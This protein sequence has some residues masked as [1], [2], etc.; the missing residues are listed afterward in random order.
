MICK[1]LLLINLSGEPWT[2]QELQSVPP[3]EI[4]CQT[5]YNSCLS[6][7]TKKEARV[8]EAICGDGVKEVEVMI[9][10]KKSN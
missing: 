4:T 9:D 7:L 3:T 10:V 6:R 5:R 2:V 1:L 8:L